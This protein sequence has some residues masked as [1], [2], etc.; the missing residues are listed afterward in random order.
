M[1][2]GLWISTSGGELKVENA[3]HPTHNWLELAEQ[4]GAGQG[5]TVSTPG[6]SALSE[7]YLPITTIFI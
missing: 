2:Q 5:V 4:P 3:P 6:H 7:N 1:L